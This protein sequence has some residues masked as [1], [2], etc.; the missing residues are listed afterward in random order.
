[1]KAN[2]S[3]SLIAFSCS[4]ILAFFVV[5]SI[6]NEVPAYDNVQPL[7]S[8]ENQSTLFG[9][10]PIKQGEL[11][12]SVYIGNCTATIVGPETALTA[13][14]CRATGSSISFTMDRVKYSGKC[15]RHTDYS[16]N[17]WLNNDWALCKFSPKIHLDVFGS[18]EKTNMQ[19]GDIVTM[20]G[21]GRGSNGKLN[22]GN[23]EIKS[24]NRMDIITKGKVYLGGGDS[25]GG[26]F[27]RVDDL[28]KGP[29]II[30][31][32]NSRGGNTTSYFNIA[33]L[34]RS[35]DFFKEFAKKEGVQICGINK[36]CGS[37]KPPE[38]C[39]EE[40]DLVRYFEE[41]LNAAK[42]NLLQCQQ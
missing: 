1:M 18:L 42:D 11:K 29:F 40:H 14:H 22:V 41:H 23:A 15:T 20:Q 10:R 32:V 4:L 19:E 17:G 35:Q 27:K 34:D 24:I 28:V 25:G 30:V 9:G 21:Y 6:Y 5:Y 16:K 31:G 13:G 38:K 7:S 36:E 12:P 3:L 37:S 8:L 26:L 39:F 33:S 2:K